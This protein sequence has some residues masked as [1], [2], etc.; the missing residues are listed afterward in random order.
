MARL[1][2]LVQ[3]GDND[4][5]VKDMDIPVTEM[6]EDSLHSQLSVSL[7]RDLPILT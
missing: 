7:K 6:P 5:D 2:Q 1:A 3:L 4:E